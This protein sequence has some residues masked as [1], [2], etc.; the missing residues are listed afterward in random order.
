MAGWPVT[1][2]VVI[3]TDPLW[4]VWQVVTVICVWANAEGAQLGV[5]VP[6]PVV[7]QSSQRF[8]VGM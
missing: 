8:V 4:Q 6:R 1:K 3:L 7:W 5:F 2:P